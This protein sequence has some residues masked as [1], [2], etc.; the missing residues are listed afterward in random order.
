MEIIMRKNTIVI[1]SLLLL[2]SV[3]NI[4]AEGIAEKK[5]ETSSTNS[6]IAKKIS[7]KGKVDKKKKTFDKNLNLA[8]LTD[9]ELN[10]LINDALRNCNNAEL[11]ELGT[12]LGIAQKYDWTPIISSTVLARAKCDYKKAQ[13]K[14]NYALDCYWKEYLKGDISD[15]T[16]KI[17]YETV[18]G[19]NVGCQD[20]LTVCAMA[21]TVPCAMEAATGNDNDFDKAWRM[22]EKAM[23]S[24]KVCKSFTPIR[25]K[26]T[27]DGVN[28]E[29]SIAILEIT[30]HKNRKKIKLS[31][32]TAKKIKKV[33]EQ[34]PT[35]HFTGGLEYKENLL[36]GELQRK[37]ILKE[38]Q[39]Y[40]DQK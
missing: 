25:R 1:I 20:W 3:I 33:I 29:I 13:A 12:K 2:F 28:S 30:R 26:T 4:E 22:Y 17:L 18:D 31:L 37:K 6:L 14:C 7:D 23:L 35:K 19:I 15:E 8:L 24:V 32:E 34:I 21:A 16:K 9:E 10:Q 40:I 39:K 5:E 27:I 11:M 38:L 36:E